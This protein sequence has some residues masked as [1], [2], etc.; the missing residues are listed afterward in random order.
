MRGTL[1]I[2]IHSN[3]HVVA[4][5]CML[6]TAWKMVC[7]ILVAAPLTISVQRVSSSVF[8]LMVGEPPL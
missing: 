1:G 3:R 7:I 5:I 8:A 6:G 2:S 4:Q